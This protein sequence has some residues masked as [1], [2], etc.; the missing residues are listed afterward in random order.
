MQPDCSPRS[1]VRRVERSVRAAFM[2]SLHSLVLV[3]CILSRVIGSTGTP[4]FRQQRQPQPPRALQE[5][6]GD[7]LADGSWAADDNGIASPPPPA[8]DDGEAEEWDEEGEG[9]DGPLLDLLADKAGGGP[10][11][12]QALR[13][14]PGNGVYLGAILEG[15]GQ[16]QPFNQRTGIHHAAFMKFIKFPQVL[17]DTEG[18][19]KALASFMRECREN[20]AMAMLTL[21]T[22]DGLNSYTAKEVR[23]FAQLINRWADVPVFLRWNH[24]M[25]GSWNVW[26]Q[27]PDLY[28]AKFEEFAKMMRKH[29]KQVA[30]VWTPNQEWG[31]PWK[32]GQHYNAS[33]DPYDP[34]LQFLPDKS[35][36]D[37]IGISYFHFGHE[38]RGKNLIPGNNIVPLPHS[39]FPPIEDFYRFAQRLNDDSKN[40]QLPILIAETS[41]VWNVDGPVNRNYMEEQANG[42]GGRVL[43]QQDGG[44][45]WHCPHQ[46]ATEWD[47]KT[48][49]LHE[50][51]DLD[52]DG[53]NLKK[54]FPLIRAIFWFNVAKYEPVAKVNADWRLDMQPAVTDVYRKLASDDY[55][56]KHAV[57][58]FETQQTMQS[59]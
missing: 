38:V 6:P 32:D 46:G 18:E 58:A 3:C 28:K 55:F 57:A 21:E 17:T 26:G 54:D 5:D 24:E 31:F 51:Y 44:G 40:P 35:L 27:Q 4:T 12:K 22:P 37:W 10:K 14:V 56:L 42:G 45:G 11:R 53:K 39:F 52:S 41:A 9:E 47:I 29:S 34:Y 48:A 1:V 20:D 2:L 50:V 49:W 19:M 23:K 16:M 33:I 13:P 15:E 59:P 30:M 36:V 8:G 7:Y 25:N 43:Q